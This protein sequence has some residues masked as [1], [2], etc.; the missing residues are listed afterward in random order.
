M[1]ILVINNVLLK[2]INSNING[3]NQNKYNNSKNS[4][5]IEYDDISDN[6]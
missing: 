6:D 2:D 5:F 1:C 4:N 3:N